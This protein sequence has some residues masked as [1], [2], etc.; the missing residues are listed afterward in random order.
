MKD[1]KEMIN[2]IKKLVDNS[3]RGTIEELP[4]IYLRSPKHTTIIAVNIEILG[5]EFKDLDYGGGIAISF[6]E[7]LEL[8]DFLNDYF[9]KEIFPEGSAKA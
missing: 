3:F 8:R 4:S 7:A 6:D 2:I 1:K 9:P 5:I